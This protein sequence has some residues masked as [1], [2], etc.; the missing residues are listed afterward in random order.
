MSSP[1][2]ITV[3]SV[4]VNHLGGTSVGYCLPKP[5]V[6]SKSTVVLIP[7]FGVGSAVFRPQLT[8]PDLLAAVNLLVLEPLGHGVTKTNSPVFTAW[9]S[10]AA[11]VQV[12]DALNVKKAFV[13]GC[14]QGGWIAARMALY[15]PDRILGLIPVVSV[16]DSASKRL[17]DLGCLDIEA[18]MSPVI[19]HATSQPDPNWSLPAD[20]FASLYAS[21][22]GENASEADKEKLSEIVEAQ[23]KSYSGD[24]GRKNLQQ[25]TIA[26]ITRDSLHHRMNDFMS[27]VLWIATANDP[28]VSLKA[29]KEESSLFKTPVQFELLDDGY[30]LP[31]FT[32]ADKFNQLLVDFVKKYGVVKDARA[33][34][35]AVG[36]V[37]I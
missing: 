26:L 16:L 34:R 25:A 22:F 35:E 32:Q 7:P 27:P 24:L 30:H 1:S 2:P 8:N 17:V 18:A 3:K 23:K 31:T 10:A 5:I 15:A 20:H 19:T 6:G 36:T 33:L 14:S 12:L 9:D 21:T 4:R 28:L 13:V 29:A 37:D 11:F